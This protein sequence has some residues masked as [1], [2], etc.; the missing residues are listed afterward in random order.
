MSLFFIGS[1]FYYFM[2]TIMLAM[3]LLFFQRVILA[4]FVNNYKEWNFAKRKNTITQGEVDC[5]WKFVP[6]TQKCL[7]HTHFLL[8]EHHS[9]LIFE[10]CHIRCSIST[11]PMKKLIVT[12]KIVKNSLSLVYVYQS[13]LIQLV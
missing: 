4:E 3:V 10:L 5:R 8:F 13:H 12:F 1:T 9:C 7:Y 11:K 2:T 6:S